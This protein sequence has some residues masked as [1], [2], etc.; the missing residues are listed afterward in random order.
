[1]RLLFLLSLSSVLLYADD[2]WL[3]FQAGPI[4]V[5]TNAG[6]QAG[7]DTLNH[8]EQLRYAL[9][10]TLGKPDLTSIW[11]IRIIVLKPG[12]NVPVNPDV[13]LARDSYIAAITS[14]T[15]QTVE[16]VTRILIDAN[17]G[18]LPPSID[19]G[20]PLLFS[21]LEVNGVRVTLGAKAAQTTRDWAR[22]H[23]L[24]VN[25]SYSGK[26]RVLIKNLQL[27]IDAE[28]AYK[29]AF[30]RT[31]QQIEAELDRYIAAGQYGTTPVNSKPLDPR[32]QLHPKE[33]DT[34]TAQLLLADNLLAHGSTGARA[35]YEAIVKAK[36]DSAEALEG[37]GRYQDAVKAGSKSARAMM[38]AAKLTT[39]ETQKK[40][41]LQKAIELNPRWPDPL[42]QLAHLESNAT[43]KL[44]ALK[45]AAALASRNSG[46][47]Q[48][49]ARLQED[50]GQFP[51]AA[52]SWAAAE[53][54]AQSPAEREQIHQARLAT[55]QARLDAQE[56]ARRAEIRKK[57]QEVEDLKA[58]ALADIR[59]FETKA[60]AKAAEGLAP[61]DPNQKLEMYKEEKPLSVTGALILVDCLGQKARLRVQGDD[62]SVTQFLVQDPTK[63]VIRG[64]GD[65]ALGCGAQKPARAVTV[66]Y[67]KKSD[68]K[69]GTVGEVTQIDFR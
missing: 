51:D 65:H 58:K 3:S 55:E 33:M 37:L 59:A 20:L 27:G 30:E 63:V 41:A 5:A 23:L 43:R 36:P 19:A 24:S 66:E 40:A 14:I 32:R 68:K 48:E 50:A 52:K 21:T 18:P 53:R 9:G 1:M 22:V 54:A 15:P 26:L 29:N 42:I 49:V 25:P 45:S 69:L 35:A 67:Q 64:G 62:R 10:T 12:K 60:N 28:P 16:D 6:E 11:P 17:A 47:W 4:E 56:A 57:E 7:R 38:E 8:L 13:K 2:R 39:D 61:L 46:L 44:S 34:G 31:P